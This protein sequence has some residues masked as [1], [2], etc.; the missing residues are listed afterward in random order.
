MKKYLFIGLT[1]IFL[2][3]L[4]VLG[5][6]MHNRSGEIT[7]QLTLTEREL[8]LPYNMGAEAENSGI[9]VR[10]NWRVPSEEGNY[11]T[12]SRQ[13]KIDKQTLIALGFNESYEGGRRSESLALYWALEFNGVLHRMEL[14]KAARKYGEALLAHKE[15]PSDETKRIE[16]RFN[17]Y[18]T[19]EKMT[20]SR[21]FF[22]KA[23]ANLAALDQEF[24]G[25][26]DILIVKG[27]AK[28]YYNGQNKNYILQ[29]NKFLVPKIMVPLQYTDIF[30]NLE[31][32]ARYK[33]HEPRY[34]LK[35]LW[36]ARL[37]PWIIEANKLGK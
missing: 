19:K 12:N 1:I 25:R 30:T 33:D 24:S 4:A 28:T 34:S 3:N 15:Q 32:I 36:G 5:G 37:E 18:L 35:V 13:V 29:L 14:Q 27:L 22:V 20:N 23:S 9:S 6:V 10:L 11:S 16:K 2:S 7:S 26:K 8:S 31:P 21:L 17:E